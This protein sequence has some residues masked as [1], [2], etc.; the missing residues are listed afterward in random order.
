MIIENNVSIWYNNYFYRHKIENEL[1]E[2]RKFELHDKNIFQNFFIKLLKIIR[3]NK[4]EPYLSN[5]T[6]VILRLICIFVILFILKVM[7]YETDS[8]IPII[9]LIFCFGI[10]VD[11]VYFFIRRKE[12]IG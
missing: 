10:L 8:W 6:S 11:L 7:V 2:F 5:V 1:N 9:N 3:Q 4:F 12:H